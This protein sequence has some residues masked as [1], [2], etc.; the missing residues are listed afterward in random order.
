MIGVGLVS[1]ITILASSTTASVN[2]TIDRTFAGDIV[3]DSGGGLMGGVDPGLAQKLNK[4]PQVSAATGV[5]VGVA[6]ILGKP[7]Q[8]SAVDPATAGEI[9]QVSPVRG[10]IAALGATGIAVYRDVATAQHLTLGDAVPVLFKDTGLQKLH[11]A[12]IYGDTMAAPSPRYFIGTPAFD[13][14]FAVRYDSQVIVK[15]AP[16][17]STA[18]ALA[19]VRAAAAGYSVSRSSSPPPPE[20]S[21]RRCSSMTCTPAAARRTRIPGRMRRTRPRT[22]ACGGFRTLPAAP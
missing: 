22:A 21:W 15:K 1:F 11:V 7:E 4:L 18:A 10:S 12:L 16:G 2:S 3:I 13:A 19:A 9:F 6:Q 5:G 20:R 14:N 17:V 8:L